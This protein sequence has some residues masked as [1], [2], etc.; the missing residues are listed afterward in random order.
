[1]KFLKQLFCF[2]FWEKSTLW[3]HSPSWMFYGYQEYT[4]KDCDKRKLF[5]T[6]EEIINYYGN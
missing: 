2:H 3:K 1:M 5:R 6:D 4:C